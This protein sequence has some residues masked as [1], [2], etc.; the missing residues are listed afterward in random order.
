MQGPLPCERNTASTACPI[1]RAGATPETVG[2]AIPPV[3][4]AMC[5]ALP[6]NRASRY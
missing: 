5:K 3:H 4:T 2:S 6:R 1:G